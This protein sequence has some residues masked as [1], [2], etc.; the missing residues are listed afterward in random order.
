M[1]TTNLIYGKHS[2][3]KSKAWIRSRR[4]LTL[5]M[6]K[7]GSGEDNKRGS[8][9]RDKSTELGTQIKYFSYL[10]SFSTSVFVSIKR[11]LKDHVP[12]SFICQLIS[13]QEKSLNNWRMD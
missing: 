3:A 2:C 1:G 8:Q 9:L 10:N 7:Y 11:F 6:K 5:V 4:K 13:I 12:R